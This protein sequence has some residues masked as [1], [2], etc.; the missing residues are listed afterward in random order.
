MVTHKLS[1]VTGMPVCWKRRSTDAFM[2]AQE[3]DRVDCVE[4]LR[5]LV[6]D[7]AKYGNERRPVRKSAYGKKL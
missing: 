5:A 4:C 1:N 3:I 6:I 2:A 7:A